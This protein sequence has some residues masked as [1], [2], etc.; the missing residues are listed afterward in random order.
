[1]DSPPK[2]RKTS[3]A[4]D[5]A[6]GAPQSFVSR[7]GARSSGRPSFQSP[8]RSSLAKSHPD[9]LERALSRSPSH[10]PTSRGSQAGHSEES[11]SSRNIGLR[12]R[13]AL[14]PSLNPTSSP[15]KAPRLSGDAPMLSPSRRSSGIQAF[16]KPP[17]RLS[18]K[19]VPADFTFGSPIRYRIQPPQDLL[20]TPE[21]QLALELGSATKEAETEVNMDTGLD[22]PFMGDNPL[23]PD[24]P[25]TPTQLGL[26]KAP[27]RPR[28]LLS[29][30]PSTR[31]EQRMERR[32]TDMLQGS[33]LKSLKF[34]S[35]NIEETSDADLAQDGISATVLEKQKSRRR[36]AA[37]LRQLKEDVTE[38][39]DW[40]AKVESHAI[41]DG[42]TKELNK[43]L[44]LL[45]EQPSH[46]KHPRSRSAPPSI[47]SLL[48]TLLPFPSN[49]TRSTRETSPLP[50]NP[51]ALKE[52]SQSPSFLTVFA[53]LTLHAR[54]SRRSSQ[55]SGLL[56]AHTLTF[57]APS[58][59]PPTLYNVT[60]VYETN[61]ETQSVT[62]LSVP[63]GTDSKKRK[64]PGA[65]RQ[66]IASR[67]AN[68]LLRLDVATLCWGINRYWEV[69]VTRAQLWARIEH[70]HGS[71]GSARGP[72]DSLLQIHDEAIPLS[73]LRQLV[74]HLERSMMI[75]KSKASNDSP[76]VLLS[77][78]LT[79]DEW[80]GEP[81]LR[82]ELSVSV[83]GANSA[84]SKK[85][86]HEAKKLF[87]ALLREEGTTSARG[88]T[89]TIHVDAI[90][91][92]TEG[93]LGALFGNG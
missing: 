81:Q 14:R 10:R 68:P 66:W 37:E 88:V 74:P 45:S 46:T 56:E 83:S 89:G 33:P 6:A 76:R 82:T 51:F 90:L 3:E 72:E 42:D 16:S 4:P 19:I 12:D 26:E 58:P 41:L 23:E 78:V 49:T 8:T 64:V 54:T 50:T 27:D 43:F 35:A 87:H 57:T 75:V 67:L 86:N 5:A 36:L 85:I 44:T 7:D 65:L 28:G 69:S 80:T 30:S 9:V 40:T 59:F 71:T 79:I 63:T 20:N 61:I 15:L 53:P 31:H 11:N 92:A 22:D 52:S 91:R 1:M 13:K 93:V 29:S 18:K 38:L 21:D 55:T 2:R 24:L 47:S 17:R 25:P 70:K 84:S 60:V 32:A 77:N 48:S 62:S 39:T 34:Q 73:E